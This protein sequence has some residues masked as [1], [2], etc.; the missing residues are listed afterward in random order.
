MILKAELST[1]T[2]FDNSLKLKRIHSVA[3]STAPDGHSIRLPN[4]DLPSFDGNLLAWKIFW[5]QF[6]VAIH[7]RSD[8]SNA[9]K[10]V[11]LCQA[12]KGGTA[13]TVIEGLSRIGDDYDKAVECLKNHYDRPRLIHQTHIKKMLDVPPVKN[14]NGKELRHL[15]DVAQQHLCALKSMGFQPLGPFV[16]SILELKLDQ[17]TMFEWQWHSSRS[18]DVPHYDKLLEFIN[19]HEQASE[20]TATE[21]T[22]KVQEQLCR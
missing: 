2:M 17:G 12:A 22:K 19:L 13:R 6:T 15:H 8:L 11:Y 3:M 7:T 10:L 20:H 4:I 9:E 14:G 18:T 5:E 1:T 21:G 16:T